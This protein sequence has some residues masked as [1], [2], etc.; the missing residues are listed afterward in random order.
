MATAGKSS[1]RRSVRAHLLG[2]RGSTPAPGSEFARYGGHTSCVAIAH[3]DQQPTLVLDAGTGIRR[4]PDLLDGAPFNGTLLLTHLHWDHVE[5]LPFCSATDRDDA[6]VKVLLPARPGGVTAVA[7]LARMMSPPTFPIAPEGLR[8]RWTF[9]SLAPGVH[10]VEGFSVTAVEVAHKGGLTY[11]YRVADE[12]SSLAY[13]PD[14]RPTAYGPGPDGIGAVPDELMELVSGVDVLIHDAQFLAC[15]G[16]L[17]LADDFGHAAAEYAVALG[18][19]AGVG[20]VV[21]FHHSPGRTDDELDALADRYGAADPA[22]VIVASEGTVLSVGRPL[23][24]PAVT[25]LPPRV[26]APSEVGR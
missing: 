14:H 7:S 19:A 15:A 20:A 2:V 1:G 23:E 9:D 26:A 5:G 4:L 13:L 16:E 12:T 18:R 10:Q 25:A 3:D 8:G 24:S 11:G 22:R 6:R 17:A 21:L